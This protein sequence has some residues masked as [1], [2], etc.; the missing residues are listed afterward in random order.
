MAQ[1]GKNLT[2]IHEDVGW[3]PGL[4]TLYDAGAAPKK[5]NNNNNNLEQKIARL[6]CQA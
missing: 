1:W 3:I 2:S 6:E 4:A 5:K